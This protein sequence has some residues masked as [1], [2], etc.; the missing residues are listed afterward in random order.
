MNTQ[1]WNPGKLLELSG[2]FWKTGTLHAGVKLGIFTIIADK[3]ITADEAAEKL[4]ADKRGVTMLLNALTAMNLL[5]KTDDKYAN[6]S[7]GVFLCKDSPRYIGYMI[8]HH[9]HLIESWFQLDKGVITGKPVRT[10]AVFDDEKQRESFLMGMFN[11]A[12]SIAPGLA[13]ET[14]LSKRRHLLDLGG[15]PGTYAIHFCM[16]NP[17]LK[18]TIYD[19]PTTRPFAEKT[20]QKFNMTNQVDFTDGNY[21]EEGIKGTYDVG[22]LSHVLHGEGHEDCQKMIQ[23]VVSVLEPGGMIMIHEFILNNSMDSPLFPAL[24]S[25]NMLIGTPNGQA[26]SESQIMEMLDKEGI[27]ELRRLP[28]KGPTESGIITGIK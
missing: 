12:M 9:H 22:W 8:M 17:Q 24:F 25:L 23:K 20:I 3:K 2:Y 14:D 21:I 13:K 28:F 1:E 6:N 18:A 27:R 4:N 10:R 7:A 26:Y 15:G 5:D 11:M 19:L 16:N